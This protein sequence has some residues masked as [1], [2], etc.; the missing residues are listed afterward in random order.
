MKNISNWLKELAENKRVLAVPIMTHPGIEL[1]G[2]TVKETVKD[3][4]KH[5]NAIIRLNSEYPSDAVTA[6]MDLTVEAEAFGADVTF[7]ENE[8]PSV[9]N[10]LVTDAVSVHNLDIPSL[11]KGRV[12]EYLKANR[13]TASCIA[14]KPI[15]AGCVG[16]FSLAGRLFGLSELM[17]AIYVTPEVVAELLFKCTEFIIRYCKAIKETGV[18]GVIMAEP[19]AGLISNADCLK[20]STRYVKQ[21]VDEIQDDGFMVILHNCGNTGH[22]TDAMIQSGASGLHFGNKV[23]MLEVLK[24][25]PSDRWVM[26]NLDPVKLFKNATPDEIYNTTI[27]LLKLTHGWNNFILST[28]CDVPPAVSI[29]K[30]KAFYKSLDAYNQGSECNFVM[31]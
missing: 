1:C 28:G 22:C 18:H 9:V 16:P 20:Y 2:Y 5:A 11:S 31:K 26:G 6:I 19:A 27:E 30:V 8:I 10:R 13:I 21:I 12:M 7:P 14:N 25:V 24:Q 4:S 23:N 3:G 15:F 29:E 17:M